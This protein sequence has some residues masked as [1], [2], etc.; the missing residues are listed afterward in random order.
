MYSSIAGVGSI[1]MDYYILLAQKAARLS[2]T[3]FYH[4]YPMLAPTP[5]YLMYCLHRTLHTLQVLKEKIAAGCGS[6]GKLCALAH[7]LA[8]T[9][10]GSTHTPDY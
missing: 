4:A 7:L 2:S 10:T 1:A 8:T 6:I 9:A 5:Q 3:F